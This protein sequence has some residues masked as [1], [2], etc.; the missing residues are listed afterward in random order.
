MPDHIFS[1]TIFFHQ[2]ED[3]AHTSDF[4]IQAPHPAP[5]AGKPLL[6][7]GRPD[8]CVFK[9]VRCLHWEEL[10]RHVLTFFAD[11]SKHTAA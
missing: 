3:V 9:A 4:V 8:H 11:F 7:L 5:H 1:L 6:T 2:F 10:F